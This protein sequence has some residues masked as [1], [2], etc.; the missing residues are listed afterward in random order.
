MLLYRVSIILNIRITVLLNIV[1]H[2]IIIHFN[3]HWFYIFSYKYYRIR[4]LWSD[5]ACQCSASPVKYWEKAEWVHCTRKHQ[6]SYYLCL[7]IKLRG[8]LQTTGFRSRVTCGI[9][10]SLPTTTR[11]KSPSSQIRGLVSFGLIGSDTA[12]M[13]ESQRDWLEVRP[14]EHRLLN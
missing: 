12:H 5:W 2:K 10:I 13:H 14:A 7:L 8:L 6:R 11:L 3:L 1:K 4:S 9:N